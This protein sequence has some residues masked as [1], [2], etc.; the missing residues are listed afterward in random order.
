MPVRVAVEVDQ[1]DRRD[2][3]VEERLVVV[4]R[5]LCASVEAALVAGRD[6]RRPGDP[7]EQL[8]GVELLLDVQVLASDHVEQHDRLDARLLAEQPRVAVAL[9]VALAAEQRAGGVVP[10]PVEALLAVEEHQLDGRL[11]APGLEHGREREQQRDAAGAVVGADEVEVVRRVGV[12]GRALG[13]VVAGQDDA[14]ARPCTLISLPA[15]YENSADLYWGSF[16]SA[17]L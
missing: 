3:D 7:P 11:V 17:S 12:A 5:R 16:S 4:G 14:P 6:G 2:A 13:V 8:G 1:V 15:K 9:H 10:L